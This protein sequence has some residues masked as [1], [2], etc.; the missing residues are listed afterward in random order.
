MAR[1]V[2]LGA[3]IS[4]HTAALHLKQRVKNRHEIVVVSPNS[5]WN[6]IPSNIWVGV[7]RMSAKQ[8]TFP[9]LPIYRRQ[10]IDFRQ[11]KAVA[12]RPEGDGDTHSG[13]V[14]LVYTDQRD[15]DKKSDSPTTSSSTR[16]ARNSTS[17]RHRGLGRMETRFRCARRHT[18]SRP[19][20]PSKRWWTRSGAAS[21]N[22]RDRRRARH[23]HV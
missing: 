3:G 10:G 8:V 16:P 6:W 13:S 12:I 2:I 4:G 19:R 11:A 1:V 14:D 5:S 21:G 15:W 22:A 7:G 9:L 17:P 20:R 23:L 18:R